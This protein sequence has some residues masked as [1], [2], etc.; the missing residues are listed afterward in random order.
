MEKVRTPH[1]KKSIYQFGRQGKIVRYVIKPLILKA[2]AFVYDNLE[3]PTVENTWHPN[4]HVLI[5][6]REEV[7]GHN[8]HNVLTP[9]DLRARA[10][11]GMLNL[12]IANGARGWFSY[13]YHN[14]PLWEQG[15][16]QRT[17]TGPFLGFS[18]L[19]SELSRRLRY[20]HALAPLLLQT[21]I[22]E[23]MDDWFEDANPGRSEV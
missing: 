7:K 18:D 19:W 16:V 10:Y 6:I 22:E 21:S 9:N 11:M 12:A 4:S 8:I 23:S 20:A 15:R 3:E 13:S 17:L 1:R 2:F 14:D 5:G